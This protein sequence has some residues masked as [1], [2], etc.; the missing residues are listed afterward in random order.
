MDQ[1][2]PEDIIISSWT[3][4]NDHWKDDWF[5]KIFLPMNLVSMNLINSNQNY[6]LFLRFDI[7]SP[8]ITMKKIAEH[9]LPIWNYKDLADFIHFDDIYY[10]L[11][12]NQTGFYDVS[13]AND[14]PDDPQSMKQWSFLQKQIELGEFPYIDMHVIRDYGDRIPFY[15]TVEQMENGQ[16][17]KHYPYADLNEINISNPTRNI[18]RNMQT[19]Y[20]LT[21]QHLSRHKGNPRPYQTPIIISPC[22]N[23]DN[24]LLFLALLSHPREVFE[25][26]YFY[27]CEKEDDRDY[28]FENQCSMLFSNTLNKLHVANIPFDIISTGL[29][30]LK[31]KRTFYNLLNFVLDEVVYFEDKRR[32]YYFVES[33]VRF[34]VGLGWKKAAEKLV[35]NYLQSCMYLLQVEAICLIDLVRD[36]APASSAAASAKSSFKY[37]VDYQGWE[38]DDRWLVV[39]LEED[40]DFDHN[41]E[42]DNEGHSMYELD[43]NERCHLLVQKYLENPLPLQRL[44]YIRMKYIHEYMKKGL[45][46]DLMEY[47]FHPR[48]IDKFAELDSDSE[49]QRI[50]NI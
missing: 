29:P 36:V 17:R 19:M 40:G 34:F 4:M 39:P 16:T 12:C 14:I 35:S 37:D 42:D 49:E 15:H 1:Q 10:Y 30:T 32:S 7:S 5:D 6:A 21:L 38:Q 24:N 9:S 22:K 23:P 11:Y 45:F 2:Q 27:Q 41:D 25:G 26:S 43:T 48:F 46:R 50:D 33:Y 44:E 31:L 47:H 8:N 3:E 13:G 20:Q 28:E 18:Y